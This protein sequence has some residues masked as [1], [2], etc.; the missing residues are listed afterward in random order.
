MKLIQKLILI[1]SLILSANQV[2]A[3]TISATLNSW[4]NGWTEGVLY[5]APSS[6]GYS[7]AG[8][9]NFTNNTTQSDFLAFCLE[10]NEPIDIGDTADYTI[11]S[12]TD[13]E[14]FGT[15][16]EV[17]EYIGRLYTNQY[18]SVSDASTAA[19]F[20]I[21][22]WEIVHEDYNTYGFDLHT[23]DFQLVQAFPGGANIAA[24][25]LNS[26]D[27]WTNNVV[28]DVYRNAG[29]QDLLQVYPEPPPIP[30]NEPASLSLFGFGLLG[31]ASMI[32]RK[33]TYKSND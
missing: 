33:T 13:P 15:G 11:Y 4:E 29:A 5:T 6:Y 19:A 16:A 31:L 25:Y 23:G 1:S 22:L 20:Q 24:G 7:S 9:F 30:V 14:P 12:A 18:A 3:T 17:A 21:A 26:L 2:S 8:L 28:V 27:S 10:V 32:R